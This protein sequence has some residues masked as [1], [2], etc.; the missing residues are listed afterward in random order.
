[1]NEYKIYA[2]IEKFETTKYT[3]NDGYFSPKL[4]FCQNS[5]YK[6]KEETD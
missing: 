5:E 6:Y 4:Y 3:L 1:M 2:N